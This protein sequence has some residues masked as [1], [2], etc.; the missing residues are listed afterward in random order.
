MDE[1]RKKVLFG[2]LGGGLIAMG[3]GLIL[4]WA[5]LLAWTHHRFDVGLRFPA[6]VLSLPGPLVLLAMGGIFVVNALRREGM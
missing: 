2:I 6:A 4:L 5:L 3:V 1:T